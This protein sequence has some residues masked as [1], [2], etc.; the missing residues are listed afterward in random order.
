V[1][2]AGAYQLVVTFKKP[3]GGTGQV[4]FPFTVE[5]GT[6]AAH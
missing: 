2:T 4:T 3:G 6:G 1:H 5:Q